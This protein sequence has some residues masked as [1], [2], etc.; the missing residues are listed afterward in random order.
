MNR[1]RADMEVRTRRQGDRRAAGI[2]VFLF[3]ALIAV[4]VLPGIYADAAATKLTVSDREYNLSV[5]Q[6]PD[7]VTRAYAKLH[8][9]SLKAGEYE[10]ALFDSYE[11]MIAMENALEAA[12]EKLS[13]IS[14]L[15]MEAILYQSDEEGDFY[16]VEERYGITLICPVPSALAANAEQVQITAVNAAGRL[17]RISSEFVEVNGVKCR[18]FDIGPFDTYAF[19]YKKTGTL[20]SGDAP[21]PTPVKTSTPAPT[22][23]PAKT[24]TPAPT[25]APAR[26]PTPA[27]TKAPAKPPTPAPT[28]APAKT[29]TPAPTKTPAKTP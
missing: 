5:E 10:L 20:T 27:P 16:P 25:K 17:Q 28:K 19:L 6:L 18:K 26:T 12:G 3:L 15:A 11:A 4:S 13:D 7:G 8:D 1:G 22:K 24:P 14:L 29:P 23:A 21:T 9:T 2:A